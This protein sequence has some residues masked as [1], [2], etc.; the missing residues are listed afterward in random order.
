MKDLRK[1]SKGAKGELDLSAKLCGHAQYV[2]G[3][4]LNLH[5]DSVPYL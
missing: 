4:L 1:W 5:G 2:L 3:K